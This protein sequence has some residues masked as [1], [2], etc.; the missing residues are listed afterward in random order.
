MNLSISVKKKARSASAPAKARACRVLSRAQALAALKSLT[1]D[2]CS[3]PKSSRVPTSRSK[4]ELVAMGVALGL[5]VSSS[6][7]KRQLCTLLIGARDGL[8]ATDTKKCRTS[9]S[10]PLKKY[11]TKSHRPVSTRQMLID[12]LTRNSTRQYVHDA[13]H[14]LYKH[15]AYIVDLYLNQQNRI[16]LTIDQRN[17]LE[18]DGTR[19]RQLLMQINAEYPDFI[20]RQTIQQ[21]RS[22]TPGLPRPHGR[23]RP[24]Y[25]PHIHV[26]NFVCPISL[27]VPDPSNA[28]YLSVDV[29]S[30]GSITQIYDIDYLK[31][32]LIERAKSPVT[33]RNVTSWDNVLLYNT[34]KNPQK[35][36]YARAFKNRF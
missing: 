35:A 30:A 5:R 12:A 10:I 24:A 15:P 3:V 17:L 14:P 26:K 19:V 25:G 1:T 9:P 6:M 29:T 23:W 21:R 8:N 33:R 4:E 7:N 36:L 22:P 20:A 16:P 18:V 27:E 11:K 13:R 2:T 32:A 34:T 28:A 31:Q